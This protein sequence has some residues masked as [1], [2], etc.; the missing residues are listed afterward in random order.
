[1]SYISRKLRRKII[2]A[3][4]NRCEYCLT[5]QNLTFATFHIDH[6]IPKSSHGRTVFENLCLSC[7]FCNQFKKGRARAR[8]P[9]TNRTVRLFN[10]RRDLWEEHFRWSKD[11]TQ[12]IGLTAQG[13]A[14][15]EALRMN[16][17]IALNA[18]QLWVASGIHPTNA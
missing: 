7:P 14:T 11:G 17:V 3:A 13:R 1:M 6:I 15:V 4:H 5:Q 9:E 8:D 18:R 10:P 2:R 16:N 12:I